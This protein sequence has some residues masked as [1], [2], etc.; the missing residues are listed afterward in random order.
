MAPRNIPLF[1]VAEKLTGDVPARKTKLAT[2][3]VRLRKLVQ[4]GLT[5][6]QIFRLIDDGPSPAILRRI[7]RAKQASDYDMPRKIGERLVPRTC[8]GETE[9]DALNSKL[10]ALWKRIQAEG[11][12]Q[13]ELRIAEPDKAA[14]ARRGTRAPDAEQAALRRWLC[15]ESYRLARHLGLQKRELA[16]QIA[17]RLGLKPSSTRVALG[18]G[19]NFSYERL[20]HVSAALVTLAAEKRRSA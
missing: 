17:P 14:P 16:D 6:R 5:E 11:A 3:T 2:A 7:A 9:C 20:A 4:A 13:P 19:G 10:E 8:I 15:T 1:P 12:P 18:G